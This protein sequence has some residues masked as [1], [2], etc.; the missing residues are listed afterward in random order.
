MFEHVAAYP[1]LHVTGVANQ[2]YR[3]VGARVASATLPIS[4]PALTP[5]SRVRRKRVWHVSRRVRDPRWT[6]AESVHLTTNWWRCKVVQPNDA[7][8][9]TAHFGVRQA[10]AALAHVARPAAFYWRRCSRTL[11]R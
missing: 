2:R 4:E 1:L 10:G 9:L 5:R 7:L 11:G 8:L 6:G 3:V